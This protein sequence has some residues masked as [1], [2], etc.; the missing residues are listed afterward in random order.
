MKKL[1]LALIFAATAVIPVKAEPVT[2]VILAPLALKVANDASPYVISG[3]RSSGHQLLEVVKD[4]GNI[5][6]LPWG[7]I[8]ATAGAPLG[9][10]ND[11][12]SNIWRGVCAPFQ[13]VVDIV[14]LPFAFFGGF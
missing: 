13:L 8:Q 14:L 11:G 2:M 3:M 12:L 4:C 9:Y 7:A 6:R 10:F 1:L 5:L